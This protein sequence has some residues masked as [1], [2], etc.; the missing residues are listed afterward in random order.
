M[1][2]DQY[3][4]LCSY[5][6]PILL[7]AYQSIHIK[8]MGDEPSSPKREGSDANKKKE[9]NPQQPKEEVKPEKERAK[10]VGSKEGVSPMGE[11]LIDHDAYHQK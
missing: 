3:S 1:L 7:I 5:K 11:A 10:N 8:A 2:I 6:L 4:P 9:E